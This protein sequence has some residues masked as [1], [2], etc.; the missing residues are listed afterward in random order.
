M[1]EPLSSLDADAKG[2]VLPFLDELHRRLALP[3]IYVSHDA[4]EVARLADRVLRM[5]Y[6]RIEGM[7]AAP[8]GDPLQLLSPAQVEALARAALAAGLEAG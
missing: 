3:V 4:G 8:G 2:E 5:R 7:A 1:D 6:G